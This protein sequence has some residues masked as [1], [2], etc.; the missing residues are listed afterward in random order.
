MRH[1]SIRGLPRTTVFFSTLSHKRYDCQKKFIEHY[2]YIYIYVCV[3][4]VSLQHLPE[5]FFIL[6]RTERDMAKHVNWPSCRAL[7]LSNFNET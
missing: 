1:V 4:V 7:F 5:T 3:C 6:R 2:I